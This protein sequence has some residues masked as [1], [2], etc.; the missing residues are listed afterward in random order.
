MIDQVQ[1]WT[2]LAPA[3]RER[4]AFNSFQPFGLKVPTEAAPQALAETT[5]E[6]GPAHRSGG[7]MFLFRVFSVGR[8]Q[9]LAVSNCTRRHLYP[10]LSVHNRPSQLP[11][12]PID[13]FRRNHSWR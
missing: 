2:F 5:S 9:D 4:T 10:C 1:E 13:L 3:S 11:H 12:C 6:T 7:P 8:D